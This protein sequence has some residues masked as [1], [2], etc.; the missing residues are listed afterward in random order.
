MKKSTKSINLIICDK[1]DQNVMKSRREKAGT[2]VI[3][4]NDDDAEFKQALGS[5]SSKHHT[6]T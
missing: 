1:T 2:L 6:N 4:G 5:S 3:V